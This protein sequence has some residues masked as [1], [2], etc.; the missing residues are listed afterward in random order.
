MKMCRQGAC[1]A[2]MAF[3]VSLSNTIGFS[4]H[5]ADL[6]PIVQGGGYFNWTGL[7]AGGN[8]GGAAGRTSFSVTAPG[9][10]TNTSDEIR[11]FV[12]G[13]QAGFNWQFGPWVAGV[14]GDLQYTH[15]RNGVEVFG[16]LISN[17]M[18]YFGTL[19]GRFGY[20]ID[21]WLFYATA[22]GGFAGTHATYGLAGVGGL[23]QN[24]VSGVWV[25]GIGVETQIWDRWTGK[26]EYLYMSSG[27]ASNSFAVPGGTLAVSNSFHDN[28]IRTGLNYHF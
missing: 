1:I 20:A 5:A 8:L 24:D 6:A 22:G 10:F 21:G 13:G 19:R 12:G 15:Q 14:E 4:G 17:G 27:S 7:Y 16:L 23:S 9:L 2:A 11:G 18:D 25:A 3:V 28:V 26:L